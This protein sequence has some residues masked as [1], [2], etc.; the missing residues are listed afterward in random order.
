MAAEKCGVA[1]VRQARAWLSLFAMTTPL[2]TLLCTAVLLALPSLIGCAAVGGQTG[3]EGEGG[4]CKETPRALGLDE[5]SPLGF[6]PRDVLGFAQ[7]EH[8]AAFEWLGSPRVPYGPETGQGTLLLKVTSLGRARLVTRVPAGAAIV[9]EQLGCCPDSVQLDVRLVLQTEGG[10]LNETFDAVLDAQTASSAALLVLL[11][12]PLHGTL[13]FEP[14]ALG[15]AVVE[16]IQL[17]ARLG[18]ADFSGMLHARFEEKSAGD[19]P[20]GSVSLTIEKLAEW[21]ESAAAPL[22]IE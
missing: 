6:S 4:Q 11:K 13:A 19:D 15:K 8:T 1:L 16:G 17:D 3:E 9:T 22:C 7:G 10:A 2:R 18:P 21:G 5:T 14:Q 12:P 20:E